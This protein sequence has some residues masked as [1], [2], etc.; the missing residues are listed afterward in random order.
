MAQIPKNDYA[1]RVDT[2]DAGYPQGKAQ[3]LTSPGDGTPLREGWIND[4][5]GF[6]QSI[7]DVVQVLPLMV[8]LIKLV[9]H[10]I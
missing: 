7:L 6:L 4:I 3:D 5:W 10:N 2:G 9:H 8:I 1:G